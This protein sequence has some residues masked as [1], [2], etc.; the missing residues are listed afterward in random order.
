[1]QLYVI[2]FDAKSWWFSNTKS[3]ETGKFP[4]GGWRWV[5]SSQV[6]EKWTI[7]SLL[8]RILWF[9][10]YSSKT[11]C[12]FW[13]LDWCISFSMFIW[14]LGFL[15]LFVLFLIKHVSTTD[16]HWQDG[17]F[18]LTSASFFSMTFSPHWLRGT[19]WS[20]SDLACY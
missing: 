3:V 12:C 10:D 15:L 19:I 20:S 6:R 18:S 11:L 5:T 7:C 2:R 1:M 13:G 14:D 4:L 16:F 8:V 9:C 17:A